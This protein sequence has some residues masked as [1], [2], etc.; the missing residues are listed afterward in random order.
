MIPKMSELFEVD[1]ED[2]IE[3][4]ED[5]ASTAKAIEINLREG[6]YLKY[7]KSKITL[8]Q[9]LR[10]LEKIAYGLVVT[11]VLI[12][13]KL[14]RYRPHDQLTRSYLLKINRYIDYLNR[15]AKEVSREAQKNSIYDLNIPFLYEN[16]EEI[17]TKAL[18]AK[19][20]IERAIQDGAFR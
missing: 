19:D 6:N 7:I 12:Q 3:T 1:I 13:R 11:Y 14:D 9:D 16:L 4:L 8:L 20:I 17:R 15:L 18:E 10:N 2:L 5:L